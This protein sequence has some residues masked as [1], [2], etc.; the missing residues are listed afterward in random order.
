MTLLQSQILLEAEQHRQL[1]RRA[2]ESGRSI[3]ELVRESVDEYL[4]RRSGEEA[5]ARTFA[6]LDALSAL[7]GEIRC[8]RGELAATALADL[9]DEVRGERDRDSAGTLMVVVDAGVV[10]GL[11]LPLPFSEKASATMRA[12]AQASEKV[13]A[14]ALLE[15]EVCS[16]LG[17]PSARDHR[18]RAG[19]AGDRV[20]GDIRIRPD[21]PRVVPARPGALL[22]LPTWSEQGVRRRVSGA[23]RADGVPFGDHRPT[24]VRAARAL[25]AIGSPGSA[26]SQRRSARIVERQAVAPRHPRVHNCGRSIPGSGEVGA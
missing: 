6:A 18:R 10:L 12:L 3:S 20:A 19:R 15:Y 4:A 23:R 13:Y 1:E 8:E 9:M 17:A 24:L 7:R 21:H 25:G 5:L 11:V 14:P 16:V 22:G 2:R 26:E